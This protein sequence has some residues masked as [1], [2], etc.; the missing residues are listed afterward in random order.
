MTSKKNEAKSAT[1]ENNRQRENS[2]A[3][4]RRIAR[5][6]KSSKTYTTAIGEDLGIIGSDVAEKDTAVMKPSLTAKVNGHEVKLKFRKEGTD[7][8]K[9]YSRR[10][11]ETEFT[12]LAL[13]TASPFTDSRDKLDSAKPEQ[14]EYYC[15]FFD[16]DTEIGVQS[17]VLKVVI[18]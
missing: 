6:I 10:G 4:F 16:T 15:Y 1:E 2:L 11:N 7:G 8:I 12:F 17:D 18:P 5:Q 13:N 9:L 14:R 3:E